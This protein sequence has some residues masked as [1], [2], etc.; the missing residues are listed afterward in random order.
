MKARQSITA[1]PDSAGSSPCP[2]NH[3]APPPSA[4]LAPL[5]DRAGSP[6]GTALTV[7]LAG[8]LLALPATS[9]AQSIWIGDVGNYDTAGNWNPAGVPAAGTTISIPDGTAT[10]TGSN[11]V[12]GADTLIDGGVLANVN[13]RFINASGAAATVTLNSGGIEHSGEFFI[14]GLNNNGALTQTAGTVTSAVTQG[15]YLSDGA[16][17]VGTYQMNGGTLGISISGTSALDRQI[18]IGKRASASGDLL[19]IDGGTVTM[20]GASGNRRVYVSNNATMLIDSGTVT[21]DGFRFFVVGR[22]FVGSRSTSNLEINGGDLTLTGFEGAGAMVIA[23]GNDGAL[24]MNGGNLTVA[25]GTPLWVGD[26]GGST[27]RVFQTGG[28]IDLESG[29]LLLSRATNSVGEYFMSGGSLFANNIL[30]GGGNTPLF[31][32]TGGQI[33]LAGDRTGLLD[34]PWF[35]TNEL[36]RAEFDPQLNQTWFYVVPEP[37]RALLFAIG[38]LWLTARRRR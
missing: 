33:F 24:F 29:D 4:C 23:G 14:V 9:Q 18:H 15:W 30:T 38:T 34:E 35:M 5:R 19:A 10:R 13:G 1:M 6:A 25:G 36:A 32:F 28:S 8:L 27:G 12:R 3:A 22:E 2:G 11:L 17:S 26:G 21:M 16:G 31:D 37:G 20:T 7:L